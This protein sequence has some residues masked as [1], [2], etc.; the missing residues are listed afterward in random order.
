M[1]PPRRSRIRRPRI[2]SIRYR[3]G[4]ETAELGYRFVL[5]DDEDSTRRHP[6]GQSRCGLRLQRFVEIRER[7]VAAEDEI[8]RAVRR[9]SCEITSAKFDSFTKTVANPKETVHLVEP[10]FQEV[11]RELPQ[12]ARREHPPTRPADFFLVDVGAE[13]AH[14]NVPH[15]RSDLEL[16]NERERVGLFA[17]GRARAPNRNVTSFVARAL[18]ES[19]Q[20]IDLERAKDG[21]IAIETGDGHSAELAKSRPLLRV[22]FEVVSVGGPV[23]YPEDSQATCDSL[24]DLA[25]QISKAVPAEPHPREGPAKKLDA[26]VVRHPEKG[27]RTKRKRTT[28]LAAT[29]RPSTSD[30]GR[31][32][33]RSE[34]S[35]AA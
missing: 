8:E 22:A 24:S 27:Q 16:P 33:K 34:H 29:G 35:R 4:H 23:A 19:G 6:R 7:Q 13:H 11:A 15:R 20:D 5:S 18:S 28:E 14:P 9:L 25:P 32:R 26:L 17:S 31:K 2:E 30:A 12:C 21:A 3:D 1:D 10:R